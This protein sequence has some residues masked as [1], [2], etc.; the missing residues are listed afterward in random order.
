MPKPRSPAPPPRR[1]ERRALI[2]LASSEVR[3]RGLVVDELIGIL[4]DGALIHVPS[5]RGLRIYPDHVKADGRKKPI[6]DMR[7]Y[8]EH[9]LDGCPEGWERT[10]DMAFGKPL[11]EEP[12]RTRLYHTLFFYKGK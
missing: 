4:D 8:V 1:P 12:L 7:A 11:L 3:K 6:Q 2:R 9:I 10:R 5:G